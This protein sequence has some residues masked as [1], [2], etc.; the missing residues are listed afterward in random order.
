MVAWFR[1]KGFSIR[2]TFEGILVISKVIPDVR[3]FRFCCGMYMMGGVLQSP[4]DLSGMISVGDELVQVNGR[5]VVSM[6]T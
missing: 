4:A 5:T 2:A 3:K 1:F 6:K